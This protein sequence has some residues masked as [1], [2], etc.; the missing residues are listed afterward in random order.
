MLIAGGAAVA[1][2]AAVAVYEL[3]FRTDHH[4]TPIGVEVA[5]QDFNATEASASVPAES[6]APQLPPPGVYSYTTIGSDGVDALGGA[7][8]RYPATSTIT[9]TPTECGV[10]QRWAP[11]EER[12]DETISCVVDGGVVTR[13]FTA[14]HRFFGQG[15][16]ERWE[17]SG[18]PRPL[19]APDGTTWTA[20][21]TKQQ[22]TNDVGTVDEWRGAVVGRETVTVGSEDVDTEHVTVS[23]V[24]VDPRDTQVIDTW[25]RAG[26]DLVVRRTASIATTSASPVGDVHYLEHYELTLDSLT[27]VG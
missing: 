8:H 5:V 18:D 4:A 14:F 22:G 16:T 25:Y 13:Q 19:D 1:L 17:C 27:P 15:E 23:I 21:C 7:G 3:R 6:L 24:A 9:V 12:A 10:A 20:E 2:A 26:T 11:L